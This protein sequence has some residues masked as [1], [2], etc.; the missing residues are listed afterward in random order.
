MVYA[1]QLR[2]ADGGIGWSPG[3]GPL[4]LDESR[5]G[6]ID[7]TLGPRFVSRRKGVLI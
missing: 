7:E 5:L 4:I 6:E 3:R 2:Y 1:K